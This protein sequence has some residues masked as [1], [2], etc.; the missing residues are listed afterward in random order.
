[1]S[2]EVLNPEEVEVR[3]REEREDKSVAAPGRPRRTPRYVVIVEDDDH[4]SFRYV[5]EVLQKVCGHTE[6]RA[7]QLTHQVH[8]HGEAAVW[9]GPLEHAEMK[10]DLIRGFGPDCF[11]R[12]SVTF[13]LGARIEQLS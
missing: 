1:M 3:V 9:I 5:I 4:H 6:T 8:F 2:V 12:Q 10:R 7:Y 11:A 13:P